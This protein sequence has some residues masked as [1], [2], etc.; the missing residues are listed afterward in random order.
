MCIVLYFISKFGEICENSDQQ[1]RLHYSINQVKLF[2]A[3]NS[4]CDDQLM[5]A[6]LQLFI[7]GAKEIG[8]QPTMAPF[9]GDALK[10]MLISIINR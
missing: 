1:E 2:A 9:I 10:S 4:A 5:P 6:K 7:S 8:L 3:V